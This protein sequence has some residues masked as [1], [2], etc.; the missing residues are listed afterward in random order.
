MHQISVR[1]ARTFVT[2]AEQGSVSRAARALNKTQ[3][4]ITK[5]VQ[6]IE[7]LLGVELFE[8]YARGVTLSVFGEAYLPMAKAAQQEF[9]AAE[10]FVPPIV[11]QH[12]P[13]AARFFRMD[14]S[15]RWLDAFTTTVDARNVAAAAQHLGV[16]PAAISASLR[17]LEDSLGVTLFERSATGLDAT[18]VS[19]ELVHHVKSARN[20][21]RQGVD[22]IASVKGVVRGRVV[23]GTLPFVRTLILPQA[24]IAVTKSH[25]KLDIV[26]TESPYDDLVTGI[27]CGDVDFLLGALR[28]DTA[29]KQ[30]VEEPLL[31]EDLSVV[32]RSGHPLLK[33]KNV[34]WTDLL[35]FSW[36]LPR[37]GTPTR[38]LVQGLMEEIGLSEP[39]HM[40]ETSSFVILRGLILD[41]DFVTVLSKH[42]I[43]REE[44]VG[45]LAVVDVSLP[46]TTRSI[47]LTTRA[48]GLLSPAANA[49]ID[50]V[51]RVVAKL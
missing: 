39:D 48:S 13:G 43:R 46:G 50:E 15:D 17:K 1:H 23:I 14:I 5:A 38:A 4:S 12:T 31:D 3:T 20:Y 9:L 30:I 37:V 33:R 6:E 8:R 47:G 28:G 25:P 45:M 21:L 18:R 16:T 11:L 49:V 35:D 10:G 40:V 7:Q 2:V 36:V 26:T 41:S 29:D 42:Q 32:V 19:R 44:S 27:R 34:A 51:K 24:I 22:E